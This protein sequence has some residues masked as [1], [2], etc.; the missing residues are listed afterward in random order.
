MEAR[1]ACVSPRKEQGERDRPNLPPL[2]Q[3]PEIATAA[4]SLP[5]SIEESSV[6]PDALDPV[7]GIVQARG[8][9]PDFQS[10]PVKKAPRTCKHLQQIPSR[11][12][13]K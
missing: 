11:L 1:A 9:S 13:K 10:S 12:T 4:E 3:A 2:K 7:A 6:I 8:N 5:E